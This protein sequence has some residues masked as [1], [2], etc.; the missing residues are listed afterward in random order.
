MASSGSF[1]TNKYSGNAGDG[2]LKFSWS[3]KSQSVAD[4][5]TVINWSVK[6]Y[7]INDGWY[8]TSGAFKVVVNGKTVYADDTRKNL[9][10][11]TTVASGTATI[12]HDTDGTKKFSASCEA[13]MYTYAVNVSGSDTFTLDTI[14]RYATSKQSLNTK[15][16]TTIK[17]NWSSDSTIDYIW[18]SIN[19]GSSW[20]G[21]NVTDGKS[22]SYSIT[23]L[24][25]G[26]TY[27]I[28][29]R[30]RR[31]DSQLKTD[32]SA[33]SVTTY[34][35]PTQSLNAKTETTIKMNWACDS[36]VDYI[37]YSTNNGAGWVKVDVTDGKSGTYTIS[38]RLPNTKYDIK[39][40]VHRKANDKTADSSAL[41]VTTYDYPYCTDSP[42]FVIGELVPLK[43][44]N[45]LSR[46]IKFYIIANGTQ[47]A[48][49]Y[50]TSDTFYEGINAA[51]SINQLYAT[52]P[53][54]PSGKY[55]VKVVYGTSTKTRNNGNTFTINKENCIP[56]VSSNILYEDANANTKAVTG[57][58]KAIIKGYSNLRVGLYESDHMTAK[59]SAMPK[60]YTFSVDTINK[61]VDYVAGKDVVADMG[62]INTVGVKRLTLKG[63]D[64]RELSA[65]SY[66]DITVYDYAKPVINATVKRKNNFEKETT[67]KVSGTYSRLTINGSDKNVVTKA[68]YRYKE[69]GKAWTDNWT[70]LTFD[71]T[72]G[73]FTCND[74]IKEF[75]N[76]KSYDFQVRV[77]D[78][79]SFTDED[80]SVV[81]LSIDEGVGIFFIS[82]N[83]KDCFINGTRVAR[84]PIDVKEA[85][86]DLNDY[87]KSGW[88]FFTGDYTPLNVPNGVVNGFLHVIAE[89]RTDNGDTDGY[90]RQTWYRSGTQNVNDYNVFV[91]SRKWD[92]HTW[93]DWQRL[94]VEKDIFYYTGDT[95][96]NAY[97]LYANGTVTSGAKDIIF[98][99]TL[100]KR[101]DKISSIVVESYNISCR[102]VAGTYAFDGVSSGLN[103]RCDKCDN[104]NIRFIITNSDGWGITNN[105]PVAMGFSIKLNFS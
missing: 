4:N 76:K 77:S 86:T 48:N 79:L 97:H 37:Y 55:Q 82:T 93:S 75:D 35:Y 13:G 69:R 102:T 21:I 19:N 2:Y 105:T 41:A 7:G 54:D 11:G 1:N 16:E 52:I 71:S 42:N 94:I 40:R 28:K 92:D 60:R 85:N 44:Y 49:E 51:S 68:E 65:T 50:S 87:V 62:T 98:P 103:I 6:S 25:A 32:S 12:K 58:S 57:D 14:P 61:S 10:T 33:L 80:K 46:A 78:K 38:D 22:G 90:I 24:S 20:T 104:Q 99:F 72:Q 26:T 23:G 89:E 3:I 83:K 73:E 36:D 100:P 96:T 27:K 70:S 30:V 5:Q 84:T 43:F 101:L 31:K 81:N 63:T 15:T 34:K 59:N 18:W 45:P 64:S 29:T 95:Y 91:R 47:I 88:W 9:Y 67:I 53:N 66:K 74:V 8:Y 56:T 39:T 17:M